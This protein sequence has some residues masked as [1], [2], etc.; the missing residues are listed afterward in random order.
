MKNTNSRTGWIITILILVIINIA[1]LFTI[2]HTV[3]EH[4]PPKN[5]KSASNFLIKQLA[6]DSIQKE[7]Y[8]LLVQQ[9]Q[10][11]IRDIKEQAKESKGTFFSLVSDTTISDETIKA[12]AMKVFEGE[13]QIAIITFHHFQQVRALCTP[14]QKKKFDSIIKE[15]VAMM[16]PQN[17]PHQ[18]PHEGN[19]ISGQGH[20]PPPP[21][22]EGFPPPPPDDN[23]RP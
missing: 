3:N 10:Q 13:N 18:P 17:G 2:W 12:Q 19:P 6:F 23:P 1:T 8:L 14:V 16:G 5:G 21:D 20:H 7:K 11:D 4:H 15:V 9:H 22:G